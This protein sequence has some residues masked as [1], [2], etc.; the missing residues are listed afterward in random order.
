MDLKCKL[1]KK[2]IDLHSNIKSKSGYLKYLY[3]IFGIFE[4][5]IADL[6]KIPRFEILTIVLCKSSILTEF[7]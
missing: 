4:Q 1:Y 6:A 5:K 3:E 7:A 2:N